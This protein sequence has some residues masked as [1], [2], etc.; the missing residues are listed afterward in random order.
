MSNYLMLWCQGKTASN[1][2]PT[3][4]KSEKVSSNIF[5]DLLEGPGRFPSGDYHIHV[6][7]SLPLKHAPG[8]LHEATPWIKSFIVIESKNQCKT[9]L[10]NC[11]DPNN[12]NKSVIRE[13]Y[14]SRML[15]DYYLCW[16]KHIVDIMK[17]YLQV[18][19]EA[20]SRFLNSFNSYNCL[21]G[22]IDK[23]DD[24]IMYSGWWIFT[25]FHKETQETV[26]R[27]W[28]SASPNTRQGR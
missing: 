9:E 4:V 6:N 8:Q 28:M 26:V 25:V 14:N 23:A 21:P 19:L 20:E 17:G 1:E 18:L 3:I 10:S 15:D 16:P 27:S 5:S 12:F 7:S 22:V 13:P 2:D 11:L 24:V